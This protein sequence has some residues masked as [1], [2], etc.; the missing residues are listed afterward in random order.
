MTPVISY[1]AHALDN[2]IITTP[3]SVF[4]DDPVIYWNLF[5]CRYYIGFHFGLV[6]RK[7]GCLAID[8]L[9][10]GV[11]LD[12]VKV[13]FFQKSG[14][15]IREFIHL[16]RCKRFPISAKH[17]S[18]NFITIEECFHN[19]S[20]FLTLDLS[21]RF[22]FACWIAQDGKHFVNRGPDKIKGSISRSRSRNR[23]NKKEDK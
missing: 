15:Q 9:F 5:G 16:F 1:Q 4:I 18:G 3:L 8:Y 2:D 10:V 11:F 23:N 20:K 6:F 17:P 7:H 21:G 22:L 13:N 12:F 19:G 14:E